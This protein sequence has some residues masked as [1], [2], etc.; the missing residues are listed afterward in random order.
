M[1]KRLLTIIVVALVLL[2]AAAALAWLRPSNH[3]PAVSDRVTIGTELSTD[4]SYDSAVY[5]RIIRTA[6]L[7]LGSFPKAQQAGVAYNN[8][9]RLFGAGATIR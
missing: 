4:Y 7:F 5:D 9:D 2:A 8:A 3:E 1:N 6:R